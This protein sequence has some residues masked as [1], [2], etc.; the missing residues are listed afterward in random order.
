LFENAFDALDGK[1][2]IVITTSLA[3]SKTLARIEFSDTGIGIASEDRDKLF[4]PHFTTKK[5]GTGLGLAIVNR[6]ILDH[7]GL[8]HVKDNHP[9]GTVFVI[10]LPH[11]ITSFKSAAGGTRR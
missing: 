4:L 3:E 5:R 2:E 11:T 9:R 8:I 1:G 6:I 7:D 10:D